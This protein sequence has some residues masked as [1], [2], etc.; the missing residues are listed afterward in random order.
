MTS[1]SIT[2][3]ASLNI[4]TNGKLALRTCSYFLVTSLC[5]AAF[6]EFLAVIIQPGDASIKSALQNDL[7][8]LSLEI[9][10]R[11]NTLLDN[12]L[13]LGRNVVPNNV[14]TSFFEMATTVYTRKVDHAGNEYFVQFLGSRYTE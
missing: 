2:G 6:G 7:G 12:F 5:N 9:S 1:Y 4:K 3:S 14:F 10:D 8:H 11:K 13:D